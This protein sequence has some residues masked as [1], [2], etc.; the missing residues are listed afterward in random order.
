MSLNDLY[1]PKQQEVL[2]YAFNHDYFMLINHGAKRTGK[3]VIDNDLFL[4]ELKRVRRIALNE[5]VENPQYILSQ[6]WQPGKER[7][8]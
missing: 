8:D 3:T 6:S 4:Y 1:T 5:G 7:A 2:R